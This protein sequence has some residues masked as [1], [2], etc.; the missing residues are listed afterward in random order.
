MVKAFRGKVSH[1][2]VQLV[3]Q[4][5]DYQELG[6]AFVEVLYVRQFPA[7]DDV[8]LSS[9]RAL[10]FSVTIRYLVWRGIYRVTRVFDQ[11]GHEHDLSAGPLTSA[12]K[13]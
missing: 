7:K 4:I 10:I 1:S 9:K 6:S 11:F 13:G 3:H 12:V 2:F 8:G 5:I